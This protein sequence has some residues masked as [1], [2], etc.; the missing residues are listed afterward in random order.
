MLNLAFWNL[1]KK[2]PE[3]E[4]EAFID[5]VATRALGETSNTIVGFA[6]ATSID[7]A[8]ICGA[9]GSDWRFKR[10]TAGKI[11]LVTNIDDN[12]F[13]RSSEKG[14]SYFLGVARTTNGAFH[15]IIV[16]F[17]HLESPF[18]KWSKDSNAQSEAL[19]IRNRIVEVEDNWSLADTVVL[20]DFN[21]DPF[22]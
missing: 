3:K 1:N 15:T 17:V 14:N 9:L 12:L 8:K 21:M 4:V 2:S 7:W 20:G 11:Y 22:E 16:C 10:S 5:F 13:I 19:K 6:E 18:G